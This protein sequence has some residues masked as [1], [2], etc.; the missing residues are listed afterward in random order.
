VSGESRRVPQRAGQRP[1]RGEEPGQ[2]AEQRA[3]RGLASVSGPRLDRASRHRFDL[4]T[5]QELSAKLLEIPEGFVV[6]RQVAKIYEDRQ[7]MQ[8]GG[9]PINWGYAETMAYATWRSKV[10]RSA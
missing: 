7:K 2:R 3:V 10:T 5:L 8:A 9:L 6:Q 1:A 4:K